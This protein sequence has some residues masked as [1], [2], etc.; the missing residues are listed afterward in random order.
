MASG[1]TDATKRFV[2]KL[3]FQL[4]VVND[5]RSNTMRTCEERMVLFQARNAREALKLAKKRGKA[6]Q[7]RYS[8]SVGGVVHFEFVGIMDLLCLGMECDED[9]VWY[10]IVSRKLPMERA[11]EILPQES[12]LTAIMNRD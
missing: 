8:N 4:R 2:A 11:A 6:A 3:L 12:A 5:G 10:G 9:E 1:K 7:H